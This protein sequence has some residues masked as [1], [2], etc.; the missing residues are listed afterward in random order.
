MYLA[1]AIIA[2]PRA[3]IDHK[4]YWA[5]C[6]SIDEARYL[7]AILNSETVTL[8]VRQYQARGEHNPRDFD[9]YVWQLPIP[10][11]DPA[12]QRHRR[13]AELAS[14]AESVVASL[15]IPAG[16]FEKKRRI[17]RQHLAASPIGKEIESEVRSLLGKGV[18]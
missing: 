14:Q 7:S 1:A 12:S 10:E 2:D 4:L 8:E 6:A 13:L 16:R 3:L 18:P 15:K 9:K 17:V 5:A 11:F